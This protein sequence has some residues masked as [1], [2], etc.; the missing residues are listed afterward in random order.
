[1]QRENSLTLRCSAR[2]SQPITFTWMK[3]SQVVNTDGR[4]TITSDSSSSS[5]EI[6]RFAGRDAGT[7]SCQASNSDG[8]DSDSIQVVFDSP[9]RPTI[10]PPADRPSPSPVPDLNMNYSAGQRAVVLQGRTVQI[11]VS[12][13]GRPTPTIRWRLPGGK[14]LGRGQSYGRVR[15]LDDDTLIV[16]NAQ[17]EDEGT[18]RAIASNRG[19]LAK[20]KT[21]LTVIGKEI[22]LFN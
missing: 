12:A 5:L 8:S 1:M 10:V 18:Y 3:D 15:V 17:P 9:V 19:G 13:Y 14:R 21:R 7:F 11:D 6:S 22:R 4:V 2:G 16:D 20:M